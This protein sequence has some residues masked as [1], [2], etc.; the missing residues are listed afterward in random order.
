MMFDC[1]KIV[2]IELVKVF[3]KQ[4]IKIVA[5]LP[6]EKLHVKEILKAKGLLY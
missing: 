1:K 6:D 4:Y 2:A 5:E 3:K